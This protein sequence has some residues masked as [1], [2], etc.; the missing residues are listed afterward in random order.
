MFLID[1]RQ[2]IVS[3]KQFKTDF[4]LLLILNMELIWQKIPTKAHLD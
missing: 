3:I 4:Y 1:K 2:R